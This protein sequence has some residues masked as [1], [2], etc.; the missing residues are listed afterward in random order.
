MVQMVLTNNKNIFKNLKLVLE[1]SIISNRFISYVQ[2][3]WGH[4]E[5]N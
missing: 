4:S 2:E 3:S 5:G 1:F